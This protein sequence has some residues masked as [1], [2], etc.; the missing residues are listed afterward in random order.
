MASDRLPCTECGDVLPVWEMS[1]Q[2][3]EP[4]LDKLRHTWHKL[5]Q[6]IAEWGGGEY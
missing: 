5:D 4:C 6:A 1:D 3:C 2:I